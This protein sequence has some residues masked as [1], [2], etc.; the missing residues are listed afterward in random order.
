M[1]ARYWSK[2]K[3]KGFG[4][5]LSPPKRLRMVEPAIDVIISRIVVMTGDIAP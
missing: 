5:Y 1:Q 4:E 2:R 3:P